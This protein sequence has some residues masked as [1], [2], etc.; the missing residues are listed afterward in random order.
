[1][2]RYNHNVNRGLPTA[3]DLIDAFGIP[4]EFA[5]LEPI[6]RTPAGTAIVQA[7]AACVAEGFDQAAI[8][9]VAKQVVAFYSQSD[10]RCTTC[11]AWT[12]KDYKAGALICDGV[13]SMVVCCAKCAK[14]FAQGRATPTLGRNLTGYGEVLK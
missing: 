7:I 12:S 4:P 6:L 11:L 1:M 5:H 3:A 13:F 2:P 10:H 14:M 9:G 8:D